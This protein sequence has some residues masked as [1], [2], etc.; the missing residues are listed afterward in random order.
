MGRFE[1]RIL[2][3]LA[4]TFFA[5]RGSQGYQL[6]AVKCG[7]KRRTLPLN[8]FAFRGKPKPNLWMVTPSIGVALQ[9]VGDAETVPGT[10][11]PA[12]GKR[13]RTTQKSWDPQLHSTHSRL[14]AGV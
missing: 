8:F 3:L 4:S 11:F 9:A 14:E 13:V 1:T 2:C 12:L 5:F 10:E 6:K 7:A